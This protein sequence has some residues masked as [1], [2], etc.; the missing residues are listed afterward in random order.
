MISSNEFLIPHAHFHALT[1][2]A[3]LLKWL[4]LN[5]EQNL[6]ANAG[7]IGP[8]PTFQPYLVPPFPHQALDTLVVF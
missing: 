5:P 6:N 3:V 8:L 7:M 4:L 1:I 2:A